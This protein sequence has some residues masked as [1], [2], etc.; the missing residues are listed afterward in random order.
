MSAG[1]TPGIEPA[2]A[3]K[4]K[5]PRYKLTVPL[6]L[7]VLRAGIPDRI[8]GR[9]IEIGE[10]GIGVVA[11]SRLQLGESVRVEFLLPH[12][13]TPVRATAVVRYEHKRGFG[14]QF[15]RL[16]VD[17]QAIIRYWTR[18]EGDIVLPGPDLDTPVRSRALETLT[19]PNPFPLFEDSLPARRE[20][21]VRRLLPVLAPILL[22]VAA[23][24][25]WQW[26]QGWA[27][28][29]ARVLANESSSVKP[30]FTV[31]AEVLQQHLRHKVLPDYPEAARQAGIQG[32]VALDVIVNADGA[33]AQVKVVSG[34]EALG[35][36]AK[37]A[38]RWWRYEPC[39]VNGQP[40][41][42]ESTVVVDFRLAN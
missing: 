37:D 18:F 14:L 28:L 5:V 9:T 19:G 23:L 24:G 8:P 27:A 7:T 16:P 34:P 2:A 4:R 1:T 6:D 33:V 26:Q 35:Q 13:T 38:V 32:S 10:G 31:R 30:Q 22:I 11:A 3:P 42:V 36:A 21:G 39:L 17:Q 12:M 25:V 29:E 40:A 15:L 41:A 20:F